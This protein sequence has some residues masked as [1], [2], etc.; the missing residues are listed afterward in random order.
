[1]RIELFILHTPSDF[2]L[3]NLN[4]LL[5]SGMGSETSVS[6]IHNPC[7]WVADIG[8]LGIQYLSVAHAFAR[9]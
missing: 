9:R 3:H 6:C 1:M 8:Y 4:I 5:V 7:I 2:C